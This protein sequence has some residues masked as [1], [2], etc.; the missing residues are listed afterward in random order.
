MNVCPVNRMIL[1]DPI[2]EEE[3]Q[4]ESTVLLP[5]DYRPTSPYGVGKVVTAAK[6][7]KLQL[8]GDDKIVF[9]NSML[10]EVTVRG[11]KS[12][13]LL[14]NYVLCILEGETHES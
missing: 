4:P 10:Q 12:Y 2:E 1:V 6:D 5:D 7:C 3:K 11:Q 13:L 8:S 9:E 14:E